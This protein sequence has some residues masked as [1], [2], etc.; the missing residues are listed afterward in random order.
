M[1]KITDKQ[2]IY[3][4]ILMQKA[5]WKD[6]KKAL[7]TYWVDSTKKLEVKTA[8]YLIKKLSPVYFNWEIISERDEKFV[9]DK[10]NEIK[11]IRLAN[12][13]F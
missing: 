8:W 3:L 4:A 2:V 10:K 9:V 5:F 1:Q 6:R 7:E 12:L 13:P 11:A